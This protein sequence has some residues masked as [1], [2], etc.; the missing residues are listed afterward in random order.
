MTETKFI[1]QFP[2]SLDEWLEIENEFNKVLNFP[3]CV[4][5]LDGKHVVVQCPPLSGSDFL[6]LQR[7]F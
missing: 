7:N 2:S 4:G 5:A 3:H 1:F 6:Q